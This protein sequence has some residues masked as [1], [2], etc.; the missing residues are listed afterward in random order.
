MMHLNIISNVL[1]VYYGQPI[2]SEIQNINP[3][4]SLV[5]L[6][7]RLVK[8][9]PTC[10]ETTQSLYARMSDGNYFPQPTRLESV[11]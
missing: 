8:L 5:V 3:M 9:L 7:S 2:E 6:D 11:V 4:R 10:K 1:P